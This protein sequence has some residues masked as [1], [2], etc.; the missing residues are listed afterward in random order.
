VPY[1]IR[2]FPQGV[3]GSNG[4]NYAAAPDT[5]TLPSRQTKTVTVQYATAQP[6]SISGTVTGNG[7]GIVGATVTLSGA[8]SAIATTS[9][10]GAYA[11]PSLP[12]GTYTLTVD[13]PFPGITFP[14]PSQTVTLAGGQSLVV[15]FAGTY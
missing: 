1:L 15:N 6:G 12:A 8:G 10:G 5:V 9:S 14:A 2:I 4:L 13:T 7:N 11:F 3:A